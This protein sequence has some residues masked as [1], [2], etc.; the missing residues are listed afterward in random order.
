MV[1]HGKLRIINF[2]LDFHVYWWEIENSA[3]KFK[4]LETTTGAEVH[5]RG[6]K[7]CWRSLPGAF[8][9]GFKGKPDS[10]SSSNI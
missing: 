4:R 9:K 6:D 7:A 8:R 10:L 3:M 1:L 5:L 2:V